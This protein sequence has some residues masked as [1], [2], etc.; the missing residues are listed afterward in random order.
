MKKEKIES[1]K[2]NQQQ[3]P[4]RTDLAK[5]ELLYTESIKEKKSMNL[6][7]NEIIAKHFNLQK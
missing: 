7:L 3:F 6:I 1:N 5:F 4:L 2:S